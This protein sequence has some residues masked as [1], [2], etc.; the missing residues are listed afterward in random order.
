MLLQ[1]G[2]KVVSPTELSISHIESYTSLPLVR[3]PTCVVSEIQCSWCSTN[4]E[5]R[6]QTSNTLLPFGMKYSMHDLISYIHYCL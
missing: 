2:F 3:F 6:C 1:G 5:L 4:F